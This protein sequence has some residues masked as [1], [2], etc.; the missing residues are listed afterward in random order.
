MI[1]YLSDNRSVDECQRLGVYWSSIP[2]HKLAYVRYDINYE[3]NPFDQKRGLYNAITEYRNTK[4]NDEDAYRVKDVL[5][6]LDKTVGA[7][8]NELETARMNTYQLQT[9]TDQTKQLLEETADIVGA[10]DGVNTIEW[11]R[12]EILRLTKELDDKDAELDALKN[13]VSHTIDSLT[14]L[15]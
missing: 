8:H 3:Y 5:H 11:M 13:A 7:F 2:V 10:P 6:M 4:V 9:E 1:K 12:D 15:V 14:S